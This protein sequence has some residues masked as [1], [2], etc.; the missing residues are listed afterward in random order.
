MEGT[1]L[2]F[3]LGRDGMNESINEAT[4][5]EDEEQNGEVVGAEVDTRATDVRQQG[6]RLICHK[7]LLQ[8]PGIYISKKNVPPSKIFL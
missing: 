3:S 7:V 1:L 2:E 4:L 5:V 6:L 8:T